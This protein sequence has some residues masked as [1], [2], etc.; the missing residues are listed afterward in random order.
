MN[1]TTFAQA[2]RKTET[3]TEKILWQALRQKKLSGIKFRRQQPI[4]QYVADF[5]CSVCKLVVEIDGDVHY[6]EGA[7]E[8]DERRSAFLESE[9]LMILRYTNRDIHKRLDDVLDEI[10]RVCEERYLG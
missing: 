4:R 10:F 1:D 9:G 3:P 2:L 5:F 7:P 8:R 6:L